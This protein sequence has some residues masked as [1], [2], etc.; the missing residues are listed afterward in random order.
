MMEMWQGIAIA[1]AILLVIVTVAVVA[2]KA[3]S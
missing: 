3:M 2:W 1:G